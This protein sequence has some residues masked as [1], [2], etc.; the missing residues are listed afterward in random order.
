MISLSDLVIQT[1]RSFAGRLV[2][3]CLRLRHG[4]RAV[5]IAAVVVIALASGVV[6]TGLSQEL[7]TR[8]SLVWSEGGLMWALTASPQ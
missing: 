3:S 2:F 5:R 7:E 8:C 1:G 4:S 6:L